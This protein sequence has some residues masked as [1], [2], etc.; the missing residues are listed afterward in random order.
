MSRGWRRVDGGSSKI[1]ARYAHDSGYTV[2]HCGHPTALWPYQLWAPD[3]AHILAPNGRAWRTLA[4]ISAY[5]DVKLW[6]GK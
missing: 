1:G 3:G 2:A 6:G 4:D 5:V